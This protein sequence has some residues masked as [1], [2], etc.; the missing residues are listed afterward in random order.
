MTYTTDKLL[1]LIEEQSIKQFEIRS[2]LSSD[3]GPQ[4]QTA[5]SGC[6]FRTLHETVSSHR[7]PLVAFLGPFNS[8]KSTLINALLRMEV[9]QVA[10][11]PTT[12]T[13][14]VFRHVSTRPHGWP[15]AP[16]HRLK[17]GRP[18]RSLDLG[19]LANSFDLDE[20]HK[21][22]S[23]SDGLAN[24]FDP[25]IVFLD[26]EILKS[27]VL[28]DV[29]GT[30]T[31]KD[32]ESAAEKKLSGERLV[33]L[34]AI[35]QCDACVVLSNMRGG[36][37]S[38]RATAELISNILASLEN[39]KNLTVAFVGT[40]ADPR[41]F[42]QSDI[43]L[44]DEIYATLN[45]VIKETFGRAESEFSCL[46]R[47][48]T[49][50]SSYIPMHAERDLLAHEITQ[51]VTDVSDRASQ[52][53]IVDLTSQAIARLYRLDGTEKNLKTVIVK[54]SEN[55]SREIRAAILRTRDF[56]SNLLE[57]NGSSVQALRSLISERERIDINLSRFEQVFGKVQRILAENRAE[58]KNLAVSEFLEATPSL[59][60]YATILDRL[61]K[62]GAAK[63][64]AKR[65]TFSSTKTS[66][67]VAMD[68]IARRHHQQYSESV[69]ELVSQSLSD[70]GVATSVPST[71]AKNFLNKNYLLDYKAS[72][73]T[74]DRY[75]PNSFGS[76][77]WIVAACTAAAGW[78]IGFEAMFITGVALLLLW[79]M[80]AAYGV[81]LAFDGMVAQRG[82]FATDFME[83]LI[84]TMRS[85]SD[86]MLEDA[87]QVAFISLRDRREDLQKLISERLNVIGFQ[88]IDLDHLEKFMR[89]SME[90]ANDLRGIVGGKI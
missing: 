58:K 60:A 70:L 22:S 9:M 14:V 6:S 56:C 38:D 75:F 12:A 83:I 90:S 24:S 36:V 10:S 26:S 29:P 15:V 25:L 28:V 84:A 7:L 41:R 65:E 87:R 8:G 61:S 52:K 67:L 30:N 19:S 73:D 20:L 72:T 13:P 34:A 85:Q 31:Y 62:N 47:K 43:E 63:K 69:A 57:T 33:Q 18:L 32:S 2:C 35:D 88:E 77:S 55:C 42:V 66:I 37:F 79:K 86:K 3:L 21:L 53:K 46:I 48:E 74:Y 50:S 39:R 82:Q 68:N 59:V 27:A 54:S 81:H 40:N 16:V 11:H 76:G 5:L 49:I 89:F 64:V 51:L 17:S 23:Y 45:R 1:R 78:F 80:R 71:K 44:R 4:L